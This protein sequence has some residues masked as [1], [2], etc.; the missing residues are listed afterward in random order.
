MLPVYHDKS[1]R[2]LNNYGREELR[3]AV[4]RMAKSGLH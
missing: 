1:V 3:G 2:Y 4:A